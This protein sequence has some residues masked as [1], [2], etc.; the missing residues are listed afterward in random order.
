MPEPSGHMTHEEYVATIQRRLVELAKLPAFEQGD[1]THIEQ[2]VRVYIELD[3]IESAKRF[4]AR[5]SRKFADDATLTSQI[6]TLRN[7]LKNTLS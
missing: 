1:S 3:K 6:K 5:A 2:I 4:L 7:T